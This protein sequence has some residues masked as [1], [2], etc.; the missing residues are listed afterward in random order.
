MKLG[1]C[2]VAILLVA[3]FFMGCDSLRNEVDPSQLALDSAKLVVTG[4]LSPQ[5]VVLAVKLSRSKTVVGDSLGQSITNNSVTNAT[6]TLTDGNRSVPLLYNNSLFP[7]DSAR[8]YYSASA[9]TLPIVA[10][11]TYTLTVT[12]PN[13]QRASSICTIPAPVKPIGITFDSLTETRTRRFYVRTIWQDPA[14]QTNFYQLGG[15]FRYITNCSTCQAEEMNLLSFDDDNRGLFSDVGMEGTVMGGISRAYLNGSNATG[16]QQATFTNRYKNASVVVNLMTVDES[17]YR[18]RQA[19]I[20]QGRVRNNPFAEPVLIPSN[21]E[22]GVGCFAGYN[23][24]T[25]TLKLQ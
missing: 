19:V 11:H 22:G 9:K 25:L 24:S 20:K 5:D 7:G 21:I 13:G 23:N 14:K 2:Y 4:F 10:G 15:T 8:P 3:P 17:Y 16:N 1:S 6:V 18:Y 12:I